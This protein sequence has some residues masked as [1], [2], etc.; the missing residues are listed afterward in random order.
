MAIMMGDIMEKRVSRRWMNGA[1]F[2]GAVTLGVAGIAGCSGESEPVLDPETQRLK[3]QYDSML[4]LVN[5]DTVSQE[6][7]AAAMPSD[8]GTVYIAN[9][10]HLYGYGNNG[11]NSGT[12]WNTDPD[13]YMIKSAV[14]GMVTDPIDLKYEQVISAIQIWNKDL[15]PYEAKILMF[16]ESVG[17]A[18]ARDWLWK[19]DM[20]QWFSGREST[21]FVD[22]LAIL[23]L[24]EEYQDQ[25]MVPAPPEKKN[26][27]WEWWKGDPSCEIISKVDY[28]ARRR[29]LLAEAMEGTPNLLNHNWNREACE[30]FDPTCGNCF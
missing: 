14:D 3:D 11:R 25:S 20:L 27:Q 22:G 1:L 10:W 16:K 2:L 24:P 9:N 23:V 13:T 18:I 4:S 12:V 7:F 26:I 21:Y 28:L 8:W 19:N 5:D 6:D 29:I 17:T 30:Q 15:T